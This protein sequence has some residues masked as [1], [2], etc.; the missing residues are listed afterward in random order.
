MR[1]NRTEKD[2]KKVK[3]RG[4]R[5]VWQ[6]LM[7]KYQCDYVC[8]VGVCEGGNFLEMIRHR[9][10]VAVAVDSWINDGV[11]SRNDAGLSQD[12]LDSQYQNFK[13]AV[14]NYPFVRILRDYSTNAVR[15]FSDNYFDFV[16]I[17]ADHTYGACYA[18]IINWYLKVKPGK[19][20]VGHDYRRGFGV[21][22]AV[23]EFIRERKLKLI[24]LPPSTWAVIKK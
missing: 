6:P 3:I 12:G 21:I 9:P 11:A 17:D 15:Q 8:E 4:W 22:E 16:Y 2:L 10:K 14:Q 13:N 1:S 7:E 18:D 23:N 20:L 5:R 19:F 24:F